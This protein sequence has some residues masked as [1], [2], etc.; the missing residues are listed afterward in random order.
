MVA[1]VHGWTSKS[2]WCLGSDVTADALRSFRGLG[3]RQ[4]TQVVGGLG[5]LA[6]CCEERPLVSFQQLDP[7]AN[8]AGVANVP[9]K[10]KFRTQ[11]RGAQFRNQ[12]FGRVVA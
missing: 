5:S 12:F 10:A 9:V 8:I 1:P 6:T 2:G 3:K 11:E 4:P 7:R